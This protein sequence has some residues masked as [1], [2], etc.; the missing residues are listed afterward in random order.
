MKELTDR[1]QLMLVE[2][3]ELEG[4]MKEFQVGLKEQVDSILR[5]P[6]PRSLFSR[7]KEQLAA[8]EGVITTPGSSLTP[9]KT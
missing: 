6:P 3:T 2:T 8:A 5:T 7:Q 4:K 1:L 9:S